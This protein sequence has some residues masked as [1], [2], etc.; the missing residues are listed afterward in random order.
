MGSGISMSMFAGRITHYTFVD[1]LQSLL[2][3][4]V[5]RFPV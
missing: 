5:L 2:S 1:E 3:A 4:G